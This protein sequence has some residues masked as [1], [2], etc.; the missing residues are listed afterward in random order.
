MKNIY[1]NKPG[2]L[3]NRRQLFNYISDININCI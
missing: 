2:K 3:L 1:N